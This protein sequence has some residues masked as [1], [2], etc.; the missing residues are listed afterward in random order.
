MSKLLTFT[1]SDVAGQLTL[2][3]LEILRKIQPQEFI[4]NV[5]WTKPTKLEKSPNIV[6]AISHSNNLSYW[7]IS[8]VLLEKDVTKRA[9]IVT[10]LIKLAQT[11][12][13]SKSF[14]SCAAIAHA[15]G[16]GSVDR[17]NLTWGVR[18]FTI[19]IIIAWGWSRTKQ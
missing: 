16:N 11:L 3:D 19:P 18:R 8:E 2:I 12:Y 9:E 14:N 13:E 4:G 15:I 6:A 17:L 5:P 10:W 7:A 1:P